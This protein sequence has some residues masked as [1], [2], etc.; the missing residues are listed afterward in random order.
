MDWYVICCAENGF[1]SFCWSRLTHEQT[2]SSSLL[3]FISIQQTQHH[4]SPLA[5][6][7]NQQRLEGSSNTAT[8]DKTWVNF[9]HRSLESIFI[10]IIPKCTETD[11]CIAVLVAIWKVQPI[12]WQCGMFRAWFLNETQS[13]TSIWWNYHPLVS[14]WVWLEQYFIRGMQ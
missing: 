2:T 10:S 13:F 14:R 12:K 7:T 11:F 6:Q 5:T 1:L 9:S 8:L 3:F 4:P